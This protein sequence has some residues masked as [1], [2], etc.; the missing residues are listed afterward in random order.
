MDDHCASCN[1]GWKLTGSRCEAVPCP[2]DSSG[3]NVGSGCSCNAGFAGAIQAQ[4]SSPYYQGLAFLV[5][6]AE[7]RGACNAVACPSWSNGRD[8]VSG[9]KCW[10][11]YFGA[12]KPSK[13]HLASEVSHHICKAA[14]TTR[15]PARWVSSQELKDRG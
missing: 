1:D 6:K 2:A 15:G 7:L 12:L 10:T 11:G 13:S 3:K 9:C 5:H 8:V 4:G 14:P